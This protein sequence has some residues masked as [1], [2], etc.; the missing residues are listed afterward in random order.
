MSK[1]TFYKIDYNEEDP[2]LEQC[3]KLLYETYEVS[4]NSLY[5]AIEDYLFQNIYAGRVRL[6]VE[7][8]QWI[9][10]LGRQPELRLSK[11]QYETL[12]ASVS[13]PIINK[14]LYFYDLCHVISALQ[15]RLESTRDFM[16]LFYDKMP[17]T[18]H[19]KDCDYDGATKYCGGEETEIHAIL[20]AIFVSLASVL[21]LLSKIAKEQCCE[22]DFANYSRMESYKTIYNTSNPARNVNPLLSN[23]DTI[24]MPSPEL[25]T[26][27][28]FRNDYVHNGSWDLRTGVYVG[29]VKGVPSDVFICCPDLTTNGGFESCGSRNKFY[30]QGIKI[31]VIIPDLV[32][33]VVTKVKNTIDQLVNLYK[34]ATSIKPDEDLSTE[35]IEDIKSTWNIFTSFYNS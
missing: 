19:Y 17:S 14:Y 35:C 12:K 13:N 3:Y 33:K 23:I 6:N 2:R 28:S 22:Y 24:F 1:T 32:L 9:M 7:W 30:S 26:I 21:D 20:N 4:A 25:V 16:K 11:T 29:R 10:K 18:E 8:S 34:N 5:D 31:N 27:E 15:D